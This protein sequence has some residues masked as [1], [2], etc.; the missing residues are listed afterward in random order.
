MAQE[1]KLKDVTSLQM[2]NGEKKEVEVE[3]VEGG[4]VL[5]LKVQ[6]QV[7]ATSSNCTH[8]GAPLVK[9][10]LTPEGRLTCPWHGACFNVSTGDVEDAPALDPIAKYE[11]VEK[12]G[13]VYVKTTQE[14]LKANRKFLNIK[15]SSVSEDKVLVIGGGSGTLGAIE[16]LRGGGYTGKITVISKEGYQPIDRTKL[17]KALLADISKAAWRQKEFYMDASIDIIEDEA[18]SIDFSGK[19]VSTKSGK[20]YDYSKLVLATGGTPRWL[21]LDGLKGDLGNVFLLRTLPDAQNIL[22]AVGDNG[23]KVVV[24]GS[25]FIGM[26]VGNC[27][28]SM[29]N[30][31]TIIGMEEEPMERVMG[32]KVGAIFRGL[33]EKNGVKFQ[34]SASVDK[35]TPSKDD[36][37]KVGGVHLKDG[38][39]LEA[40]LVI[41][42]VGVAPATEYLK[43]N[44]SVTLEKDG[45]LKTDESFA[46]NGLKDVYA[47]GDIATYPYHGP[48]G[49]GSP[50]RIEHWNVA[51]NAGR[52]VAH[53]INNPGSKPKPFI[54]VFWSALGSQLRYCGNTVGGYD[55]VMLQGEPDK[56]SFVAYYT[57]GETVVAVAS[58]MKDPYMTQAAE[59]MRRKVMASKSELQKGVDIMEIGLPNEIKM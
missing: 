49:D 41:E 23:K 30:D 53:T 20:E 8:Y 58:M 1:F 46:V 55:D 54:P 44:S 31:V 38:T 50:V 5:L 21:P 9:G 26:E 18:K 15:C 42:G 19:T 59:L 14:A 27:L 56:A 40:D 2:K 13:A 3:G 43:G 16:G 51:Q 4:K 24:V 34:M 35:A 47:I 29:K 36:S 7:H 6:D 25:S 57:K 37:S 28:A 22:K 48:G 33:L 39:V 11:V 45:S 32:K 52:S 12:D 17:S 10:V